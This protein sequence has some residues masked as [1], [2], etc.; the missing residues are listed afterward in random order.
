MSEILLRKVKYKMYVINY[1]IYSLLLI[2][3]EL[4]KWYNAKT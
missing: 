1:F 2:I 4:T 3:Y